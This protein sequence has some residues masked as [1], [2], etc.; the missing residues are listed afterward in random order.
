MIGTD[1]RDISE[2]NKLSEGD[3][4]EYV[5]KLVGIFV[6]ENTDNGEKIGPIRS[7]AAREIQRQFEFKD[8]LRAK[9]RNDK[10]SL[11]EETKKVQQVEE[12][13]RYRTNI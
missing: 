7:G 2:L 9:K 5:I 11:V 4:A 3:F 1:T 6:D 8:N 12:P 13:V 10:W